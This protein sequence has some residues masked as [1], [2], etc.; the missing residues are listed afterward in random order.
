M[1]EL[2]EV[3]TIRCDLE[4]QLRGAVIARVTVSR[5]WQESPHTRFHENRAFR[6]RVGGRAIAGIDRRGKYLLFRLSPPRSILPTRGG[7]AD[8]LVVHLG[9][10]GQLLL[11]GRQARKEPHTHAVFTLADAR[12][13][14]FEDPRMFGRLWVTERAHVEE[15]LGN[16]GPEPLASRFTWRSL[17]PP[18]AKRSTPIKSAL[19]DPRVVAGVGNIYSD[20]ALFEAHLH[21][22]RACN[23]LS[24]DEL[25]RLTRAIKVVLRRGVRRRGTT[26][27]DSRYRDAFGAYGGNEPRAYGREGDPCVGCGA[28]IVRGV[29]GGRSYH[30]CPRC[31]K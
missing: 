11:V 22:R 31:Q 15:R 24:P 12:E 4:S 26:L 10:S 14:R 29:L 21:P 28:P 27:S 18:L 6:Q 23:S 9:M 1:P 19:L 2:P 3:E 7:E 16:L 25:R 17:A 30:F 13:L 20:E 8:V 5:R